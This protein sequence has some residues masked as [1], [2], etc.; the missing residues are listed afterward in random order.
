MNALSSA[1]VLPAVGGVQED[2]SERCVRILWTGGW[3]STFRVLYATLVDGK[4]VEPHY[5]IDTARPSS[6]RELQAI[7]DVKALL[8]VSHQE[9]YERIGP[10]QTI[11][12]LE[13][14]ED[15]EST[16]AWKRLKQ[17][18]ALGEQYDW[19]A[20]YAK[21]RNLT[22]LELSV[23]I[24]DRAY[25]F[26]KGKVEQ[27]PLGGYRLRQGLSGDEHI[28]AR[29][30][31]PILEYSKIQ[32]RDIARKHGFLEILEKSWFCHRPR[33]GM[34]CGTCNPCVFTVEEG[35]RY[36]LH[37][38]ALFKYHMRPYRAAM[39]ELWRFVRKSFSLVRRSLSEVKVL[40][41]AYDFIRYRAKRAGR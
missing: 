8:K 10:L 16:N 5:I 4:Q 11:S 6:L 24:D 22:A 23:H 2:S 34:P 40:R 20:R 30:E 28:F 26:L 36:R 27:S 17:R 25:S 31:F 12:K 7:A 32:M 9:A 13:I 21:S 15:V 41:Q 19:L 35:L 18:S 3:D 37:R 14:P 1:Q 29:F 33:K 38:A 39:T